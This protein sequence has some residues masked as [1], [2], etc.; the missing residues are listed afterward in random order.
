MIFS[1]RA[2]TA[3]PTITALLFLLLSTLTFALPAPPQYPLLHVSVPQSHFEV[4]RMRQTMPLSPR[5]ITDVQCI[6]RNAH[7]VF[8]DQNAA[9]LSICSDIS[10]PD[11]DRCEGS[12]SMTQGRVGSALFTL[13]AIDAGSTINVTKKKW[14]QCI[15]AARAVC[16]TGSLAA[17]CLGG[18]SR[19]DFKF[20]LLSM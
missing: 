9:E 5:S 7:I 10:G 15:R 20:T 1:Q 13:K 12:L 19:G 6:D 8:H 4:L 2:T 3:M 18:A 17:T 14:E 11:H 16:P